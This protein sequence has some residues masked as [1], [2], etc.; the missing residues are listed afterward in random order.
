VIVAA[1]ESFVFQSTIC[2]PLWCAVLSDLAKGRASLQMPAMYSHLDPGQL[3]QYADQTL[4]KV[5]PTGD[6]PQENIGEDDLQVIEFGG[7]GG[8]RTLDPGIMSA[9]LRPPWLN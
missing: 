8:N 5:S 1:D 6:A 4:I 7:K 9:L 2:W 3:T